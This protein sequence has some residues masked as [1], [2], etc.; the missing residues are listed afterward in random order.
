MFSVLLDPA[1]LGDR[2]AFEDEALAFIDWVKASPARDGFD[3]VQVA[4]DPERAS[5]ARRTAEGVPVDATTWQEI[6]TRRP[7]WAWTRRPSMRLR[8]WPE[9]QEL[10]AIA[11]LADTRRSHAGATLLFR[12]LIARPSHVTAAIRPASAP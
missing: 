1:V 8:A 3:A 2:A 10:L 6:L 9:A 11:H 5:R 12:P 4:G 7:R